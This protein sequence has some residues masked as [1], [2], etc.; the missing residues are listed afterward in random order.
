MT[1]S[2]TI[3]WPPTDLKALTG[4]L[5]PPGINS[6][7]AEKI[8]S[9]LVEF[10]ILVTVQLN[11]ALRKILSCSK[12]EISKNFVNQVEILHYDIFIAIV[13]IVNC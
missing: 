13:W 10:N 3:G 1:L 2:K 8:S 6:W 9:D 4:E 11:K 5:T 12:L 7:A